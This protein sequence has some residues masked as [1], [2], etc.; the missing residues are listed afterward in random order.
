MAIE[1]TIYTKHDFCTTCRKWTPHH[2]QHENDS[3]TNGLKKVTYKTSCIVH[4]EQALKETKTV[5]E[6]I[7]YLLMADKL[8]PAYNGQTV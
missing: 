5:S 2:V 6:G 8:R 7:Y 3:E 4:E 1:K